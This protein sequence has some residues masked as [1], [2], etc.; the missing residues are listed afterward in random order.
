[1]LIFTKTDKLSR[2]ALQANIDAFLLRV[3]EISEEAPPV[4][5]SSSKDGD[6]RNEILGTIADALAEDPDA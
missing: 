2:K 5:Q 1:M 4:L 6:G 3:Q